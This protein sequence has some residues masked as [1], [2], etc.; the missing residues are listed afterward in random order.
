[1]PNWPAVKLGDVVTGVDHHTAARN[2]QKLG[3]SLLGA[4]QFLKGETVLS[5]DDRL[6]LSR[7]VLQG[8]G[9]G[10][11]QLDAIAQVRTRWGVSFPGARQFV[12]AEIVTDQ[13]DRIILARQARSLY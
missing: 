5:R 13:A 1:M 12:A 8:L 9:G 2:L 3:V 11:R 10:G 7:I 6:V 4:Q